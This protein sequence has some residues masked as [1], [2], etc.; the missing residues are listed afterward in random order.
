MAWATPDNVSGMTSMF[1]YAAE[2]FPN[3]PYLVLVGVF[4]VLTL[5][6]SR[7]APLPQSVT[8]ASFI[9]WTF[10]VFMFAMGSISGY[11]VVFMGVGTAFAILWTRLTT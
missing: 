3:F 11:Y 6:F 10:G 7:A 4:F 5:G 8:A 2:L 1:V 9:T